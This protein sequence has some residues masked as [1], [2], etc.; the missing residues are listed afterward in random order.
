[1][2]EPVVHRRGQQVVGL[3]VSEYEVRHIGQNPS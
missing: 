2:S 3:A 1:L